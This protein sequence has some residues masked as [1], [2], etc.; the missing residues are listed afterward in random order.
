MNNQ[1]Y[2][3]F[4]SDVDIQDDEYLASNNKY[5][6]TKKG[7]VLPVVTNHREVEFAKDKSIKVANKNQLHKL[8]DDIHY[9]NYKN[10]TELEVVF[11]IIILSG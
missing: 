2:T 8:F 11:G 4:L 7:Y 5:Q 9:G 1:G 10:H 3:L 6:L